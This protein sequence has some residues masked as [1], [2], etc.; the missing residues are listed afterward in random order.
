MLLETKINFMKGFRVKYGGE[1]F[2]IGFKEVNSIVGIHADYVASRDESKLVLSGHNEDF[3]SK[4]LIDDITIGETIE[5]QFIEFE[6]ISEPIEKRPHAEKKDD[7]YKIK[8]QMAAYERLKKELE[9]GG[10]I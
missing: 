6:E 1:V 5:I 9:E 8:R 7:K 4:W 3:S 2:Y 10:H